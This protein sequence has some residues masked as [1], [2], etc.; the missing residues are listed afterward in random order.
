MCPPLGVNCPITNTVRATLLLAHGRSQ[1]VCQARLEQYLAS[2]SNPKLDLNSRLEGIRNGTRSPNKSGA[3]TPRDLNS[4]VKILEL[5][6][7]H[8]LLRNNEWDLS[9]QIISESEILDEERREAFLQAFG[10]LRDER[11]ELKA[12]E[13]EQQLYE[14]EVRKH[15][16]R[17]R[18]I[19]EEEERDRGREDGSELDY[20]VE[21]SHPSGSVKAKSATGSSS[22]H[23]KTVASPTARSSKPVKKA[24]PPT[25]V[26]RASNI[27][28]NLR[29]LL[30]N[31][32]SGF[33]KNP[34]LLLRMMAFIIGFLMVFGQRNVRERIK[35][36]LGQGWMKVR[37]T[38]GMGVKVSYI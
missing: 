16:E 8:V 13:R 25:L 14:E 19:R 6:T 1:K 2:S 4:R 35:R 37:Q 3:N 31:M 29:A 26:M 15:E 7:L 20:G 24:A 36:V 33:A 32:A 17:E 11:D 21:E 34:M 38:A 22:G 9:R 30:D 27:I 12:R 23:R 18:R 28:N 5:Y 10:S